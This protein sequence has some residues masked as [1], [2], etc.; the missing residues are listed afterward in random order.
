MLF[1]SL[2]FRMTI[3]IYIFALLMLIFW[4]LIFD[5]TRISFVRHY[6]TELQQMQ[7]SVNFNKGKRRKRTPKNQIKKK[8]NDW[9]SECVTIR[10]DVF[11]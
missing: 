2:D 3:I 4:E 9:N 1:I 10:Y 11:I 8:E 5:T 6:L 7:F